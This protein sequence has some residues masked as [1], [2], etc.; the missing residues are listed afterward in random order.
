M[1]PAD[2]YLVCVEGVDQSAHLFPPHHD[3][4]L[5]GQQMPQL[6]VRNAFRGAAENGTGRSRWLDLFAT[7]CRATN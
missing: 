6:P 7:C 2:V 3:T 5:S 4:Q 1:Q